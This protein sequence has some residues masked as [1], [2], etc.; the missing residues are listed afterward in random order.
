MFDLFNSTQNP[1]VAMMA[2]GDDTDSASESEDTER[3]AFPF[4]AMP[5]WNPGMNGDAANPMAM[6]MSQMFAMHMMFMQ[7]MFMM[8]MQM[9]QFMMNMMPQDSQAA[10]EDGT[11]APADGS[12]KLGNMN[13]P[14]EMLKYLMQMDMS[15][16]NLQKLQKVLDTVFA[17][18]PDQKTE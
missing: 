2:M 6:M 4:S 11:P 8:P 14:P 13:V 9:M 18:I 17:A 15:P 16:E 3:N 5:S 1:F 7:G 10:Q 12:F